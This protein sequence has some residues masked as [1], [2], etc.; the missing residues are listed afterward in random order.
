[1]TVTA[2]LAQAIADPLDWSTTL[3]AIHQALRPGG[4]LLFETRDPAARAWREWT[5]EATRR[6]V[7]LPQVGEVTTWTEVTD[8]A[9]PL[10][11]FR[12]S[13]QFAIDGAVLTSSSTLRFRAEAEVGAD[14]RA[15]GSDVV[16]VCDAPDRPWREHVFVAKR[17]D[18]A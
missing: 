2:I 7:V 18:E 8:V 3:R 11:S 6:S 1:M 5:R 15:H 9:G 16:N 12:S 10:V 14:L 17:G 4:T 13:W